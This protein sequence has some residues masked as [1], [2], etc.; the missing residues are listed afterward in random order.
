[1]LVWG[2]RE[3]IVAPA[4][5]LRCPFPQTPRGARKR[6]P[7]MLALWLSSASVWWV[8]VAREVKR[9]DSSSHITPILGPGLCTTEMEHS[10]AALT[11]FQ[12]SNILE[13]LYFF[14]IKL[15]QE[16]WEISLWLLPEGGWWRIDFTRVAWPVFISLCVPSQ[17][18]LC[19]A[20]SALSAP[21]VIWG[22]ALES[23][24]VAGS[25]DKAA[26]CARSVQVTAAALGS[27][28]FRRSPEANRI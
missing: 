26:L 10:L 23:S 22:L 12:E 3:L 21:V 11:A 1:M 15:A 2:F 14:P 16:I 6:L 27:H 28:I 4:L 17:V 19:S 24:S 9:E 5:P 7:Y 13:M 25:E 20:G 8:P 18:E